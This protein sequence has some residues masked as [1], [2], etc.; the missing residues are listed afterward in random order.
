[1]YLKRIVISILFLELLQVPGLA[2]ERG[3]LVRGEITFTRRGPIYI[4]LVS[5]EAFE[6]NKGSQFASII[7]VGPGDVKKG[8]TCFSF[9]N[10]PEGTYGIKCFQD[11]NGNKTPDK[12]IFG[13]K[14]PWGTYR[15]SR[16]AF[17]APEFK[18]IAFKVDRDITDIQLELK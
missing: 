11:L 7:E 17:G 6:S 12:G 15:P 2:Q 13:P 4:Q 8:K 18:E 5:K 16:P 3:F 10:V 1:M 9:M 14:E